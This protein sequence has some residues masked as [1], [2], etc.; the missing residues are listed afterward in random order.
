M[1]NVHTFIPSCI[2]ISFFN[3]KSKR[4]QFTIY[5]Y[6]SQIQAN[7]NTN[8][9]TIQNTNAN[10]MSATTTTTK[11]QLQKW[12]KAIPKVELHAH[13]NG[14]ISGSTIQCL[15]KRIKDVDL[16]N[17]LTEQLKKCG[18]HSTMDE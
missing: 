13:L 11:K 12:C 10:K 14:S 9:K 15:L 7:T 2:H 4:K 16:K 5:I 18:E 1:P 8:I 6:F 3:C 17:K